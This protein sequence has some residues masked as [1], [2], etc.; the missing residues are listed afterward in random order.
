MQMSVCMR[1]Y[2]LLLESQNNTIDRHQ[3]KRNV[4]YHLPGYSDELLLLD[5]RAY[6]ILSSPGSR[7]SSSAAPLPYTRTT[8]KMRH[9]QGKASKDSALNPSLQKDDSNSRRESKKSVTA[10][11][12]ASV[13]S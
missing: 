4:P 10:T 9:T 5:D 8:W 3:N 7:P 12:A 11:A 13:T 2:S 6:V 1:L